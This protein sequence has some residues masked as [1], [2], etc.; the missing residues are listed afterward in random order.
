M[1]MLSITS[2]YLW[3]TL[4]NVVGL[5]YNAKTDVGTSTNGEDYIEMI[6]EDKKPDIITSENR[7]LILINF[8]LNIYA[9]YQDL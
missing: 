9:I 2:W 7:T 8:K 4:L 6:R 3:K 1:E 5:I